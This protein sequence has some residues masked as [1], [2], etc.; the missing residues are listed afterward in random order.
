MSWVEKIENKL[1][2]T[3]G[4]GKQYNPLW[5]NATKQKEYNTAQFEFAEVSGTLVKRNKPMGREY[6]LELYFTGDD[7]LDQS[8][9]FEKS[10][11][12]ERAWTLQHPYYGT[13][14]VQPIKIA[15]DNTKH[16]VTKITATVIETIVEDNPKSVVDAIEK[17]KTDK[18]NLDI[19]FESAL[20]E[21]P[22]SADINSLSQSNSNNRTLGVKIIKLPDEAEEYLNLFNQANAAI[23][24]ATA[25]PLLA[26]RATMAVITAPA[27]FTASVSS[28][29]NLL[30]DQFALLRNTVVNL[31]S[32]SAKQL[33]QNQAGTFLSSMALA[34]AT[35]L[36]GDYTNSNSVF[37]I[38]KT[39]MDDYDNLM[40][41][42]D[43][44]QSDNGGS[45]DSFIPS[46]D[47]IIALNSLM[48]FTISSLFSIALGAKK[49]RS[50]I[51]E[52]DTNVIVLTH[53]FYGLDP[54]DNNITEMI[55]NN[56]WGLNSLLQI[57]KGTKVVYYI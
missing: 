29:V 53:R 3:T 42:L 50:I 37:I 15:F 52:H 34:A 24:T 47:A 56:G 13:L 44:L 22:G 32:V 17:I 2:I 7:N 40:L 51:T 28:R 48:S 12:D 55:T 25:S 45:E 9:A 30:H 31:T 4:D 1:I 27:K 43:S 5:V 38:I 35:P 54:S 18:A 19:A 39:L 49:E 11:D 46:A 8:E 41:D 6:A 33:F 36:Q 26:M 21:T 16:N 23:N 14:V 20:T 10:A 57:K